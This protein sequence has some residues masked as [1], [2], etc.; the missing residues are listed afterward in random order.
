MR[1]AYLSNVCVAAAARRQGIAAAL[2][3][4]ASDLAR[5][6]GVEHMYVH[7]VAD[8]APAAQL[9]R[10]LGFE[11]EAQESEAF[12]RALRRPRRLLLHKQLG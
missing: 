12:A 4:A 1:R 2:I 3:E 6:R 5:S 7:V 11:R 9:Y 10:R 8:N